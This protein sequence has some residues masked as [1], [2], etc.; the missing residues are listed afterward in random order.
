MRTMS[1]FCYW[2][3]E[4]AYTRSAGDQSHSGIH[5]PVAQQVHHPLADGHVS[6]QVGNSCLIDPLGRCL[7]VLEGDL[8]AHRR[9]KPAEVCFPEPGMAGVWS[10]NLAH[11]RGGPII[12]TLG[13]IER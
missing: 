10:P 11:T 2:G 5:R 12:R 8:E 4:Y 6:G 9:T 7:L 3:P 13:K 1:L